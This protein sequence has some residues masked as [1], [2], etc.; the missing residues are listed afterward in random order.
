MADSQLLTDL[1]EKRILA[2]CYCHVIHNTG[3][4]GCGLAIREDACSLLWRWDPLAFFN[5]MF[6]CTIIVPAIFSDTHLGTR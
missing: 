2:F 3:I 1:A 6:R 5:L 4:G